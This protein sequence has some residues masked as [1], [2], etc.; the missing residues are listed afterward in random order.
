MARTRITLPRR[1]VLT[2]SV[3]DLSPIGLNYLDESNADA[4]SIA[5]ASSRLRG[6][7][8]QVTEIAGSAA[9]SANKVITG[10]VDS[11]WTALRGLI[12]TTT[13]LDHAQT[14]EAGT[15]A[16][17]EDVSNADPSRPVL[18][19]RQ[20]STF[21]L[22]S[23]TASVASIAAS[24]AATAARSRSRATSRA[25]ALEHGH[26]NTGTSA[27]TQ[28]SGNQEMTEVSSRP[29]SIR[30]IY[31]HI[32]ESGSDGEHGQ[33]QDAATDQQDD[34]SEK[35][36]SFTHKRRASDVRSIRSVSSMMRDIQKEKDKDKGS[37]KEKERK[38]DKDDRNERISISNR[39]ASIGK[40][41]LAGSTPMTASSS[42]SAL[43]V[44]EVLSSGEGQSTTTDASTSKVSVRFHST[45]AYLDLL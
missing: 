43:P 29:E 10:V 35:P 31:A 33:D 12:G 3:E 21:S 5:S 28:W 15:G 9:D 41:G 30:D 14:N 27:P 25:S 19:P 8:F 38:E 36:M 32:D 40:L 23:V 16:D 2:S 11:S 34:T 44:V 39:L 18:R 6:R 1:R 17:G 37:E 7:V 20:A 42:G 4:A 24:A 45:T 26:G 22:A 13:A